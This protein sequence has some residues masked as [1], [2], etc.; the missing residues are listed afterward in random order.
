MELGGHGVG[1]AARVLL[2]EGEERFCVS[3]RLGGSLRIVDKVKLPDAPGSFQSFH[4][5]GEVFIDLKLFPVYQ[6]K[7]GQSRCKG[8]VEESGFFHG[9]EILAIDPHHVNGTASVFTCDFFRQDTI[10]NV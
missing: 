6:G 5:D 1:D 4:W 8:A 3:W 7:V 2:C 10:Y 9:F